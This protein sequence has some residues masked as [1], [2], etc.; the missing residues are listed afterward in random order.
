MTRWMARLQAISGMRIGGHRDQR[1]LR[2]QRRAEARDRGRP[3][4]TPEDASTSTITVSPNYFEAWTAQLVAAGCVILTAPL[5]L[6]VVVVNE[7]FVT[8]FLPN[9]G[10]SGRRIRPL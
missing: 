10:F 4:A 3:A 1:A 5:D 6:R 9:E 8:R 7:R 2:R